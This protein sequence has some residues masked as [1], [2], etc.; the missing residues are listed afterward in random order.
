L[1]KIINQDICDNDSEEDIDGDYMQQVN[2][3]G[4]MTYP[5]SAFMI[6]S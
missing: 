1:I 4:K 2:K 3:I 6:S 5:I